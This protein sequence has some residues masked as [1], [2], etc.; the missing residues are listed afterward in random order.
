MSAH[1]YSFETN[2]QYVNKADPA[3][4]IDRKI[5]WLKRRDYL[6]NNR[7]AFIPD[8]RPSDKEFHKWWH[9]KGKFQTMKHYID[10][11]QPIY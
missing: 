5:A 1:S 7:D 6:R 9:T 3:W 2:I 10:G 11:E 4:D 8:D